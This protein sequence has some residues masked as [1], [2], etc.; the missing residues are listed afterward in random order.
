MKMAQMQPNS[1]NFI[2]TEDTHKCV[3]VRLK[4]T[5][6]LIGDLVKTMTAHPLYAGPI[7]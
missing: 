6:N 3:V 1:V 5:T 2:Q 4:Q 7:A